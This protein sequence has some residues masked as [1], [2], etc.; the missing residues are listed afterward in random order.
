MNTVTALGKWTLDIVQ[1]WGRAALFLRQILVSIPAL[2]GR[3]HLVIT[4]VFSTG[5]LTLIII[6][7]SGLFVGMVLG[8]QGYN[9]LVDFGA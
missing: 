5:V 4:Q 9:T 6:M 2:F 7:V 3:F 8:L 1:R